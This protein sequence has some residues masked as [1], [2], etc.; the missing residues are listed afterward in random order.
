MTTK[1]SIDSLLDTLVQD[2]REELF[3]E[4]HGWVGGSDDYNPFDMLDFI[5]NKFKKLGASVSNY[6]EA[7]GWTGKITVSFRNKFRLKIIFV[8]DCTRYTNGGL[9]PFY[10]LHDAGI[11]FSYSE[12]NLEEFELWLNSVVILDKLVA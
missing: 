8:F 1:A 2:V 12:K 10:N 5:K 9:T 7:K 11:G 3:G 6:Q 4:D